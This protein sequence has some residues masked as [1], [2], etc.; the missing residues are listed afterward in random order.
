MKRIIAVVALLMITTVGLVATGTMAQTKSGGSKKIPVSESQYQT[1]L[2]QCGYANTAQRRAACRSTVKENYRVGPEE[3]PNLDCRSYAGVSVCG[4]L[5]L[6]P[7]ERQC[8]RD[9]V[10]KGLTYR[11]AEVE[12]YAFT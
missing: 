9:S 7:A 5:Q 2:D 8:V 6:T 3:N 12:C 10:Q 1:L 4:K 11:R